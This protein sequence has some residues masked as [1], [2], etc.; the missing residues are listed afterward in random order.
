MTPQTQAQTAQ[1]VV[2]SVCGNPDFTSPLQALEG[3]WTFS[4]KGFALSGKRE[5]SDGIS[6][7]YAAAGVFTASIASSTA[8][9]RTGVLNITATVNSNGNVAS[10]EQRDGTYTVFSDCSGG[11]LTF[12]PPSGKHQGDNRF[13][14]SDFIGSSRP[15]TFDFWLNGATQTISFVNTSPGTRC[16]GCGSGDIGSGDRCWSKLLFTGRR[17]GLLLCRRL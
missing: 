16:S 14:S 12:L 8:T 5:K 1:V 7:P 9:G 10:Q 2:P 15:I 3:T 4:F 11:T 6:F 17:G 13:S